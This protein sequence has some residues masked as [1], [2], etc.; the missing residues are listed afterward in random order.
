MLTQQCIWHSLV[1]SSL[2]QNLPSCFLFCL[3]ITFYDFMRVRVTWP[4]SL[5]S[6]IICLL[7]SYPV[8]SLR[9][10]INVQGYLPYFHFHM[11]GRAERNGSQFSFYSSILISTGFQ[12]CTYCFRFLPII[13][14]NGN[15]AILHFHHHSAL[16]LCMGYSINKYCWKQLSAEIYLTTIY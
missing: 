8:F 6:S 5:Q 15:V 9:A 2:L 16:A 10:Q 7:D 14:L 3:A 12:D 13:C 1:F 4:T 11:L